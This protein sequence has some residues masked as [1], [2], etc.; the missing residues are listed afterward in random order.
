MTSPLRVGI[1]GSGFGV[2]AHLPALRAHPRFEPV[3]LASPTR[4]I[5]QAKI[6]NIPHAYASALEMIA[7]QNLDAVIIASPPFAHHADTLAALEAGL[8]VL[9]EK[10]MGLSIAECEAMVA[11]EKAA[12]TACGI[13]FEF[14]YVPQRIALRE[15]ITNGH[16]APLRD[17]EITHLLRFL[18]RENHQ[19][20]GWWFQKATGGGIAGAILSHAID[21]AN[22]LVDRAPVHVTGILRTANLHRE[23][24]AG[25]FLSEV[26]DGAF[27]LLD[28]GDGLIARLSVDGCAAVESFT[29]AVHGEDRTA[30]ASGTNT[31]DLRLFSVDEEETNELECAA[32]P[33]ARYASING[34]VPLLVRLYDDW[35]DA[36]DGKGNC[37]PRFTDGLAVQRVLDALGYVRTNAKSAVSSG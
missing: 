3:A 22:F 9:C 11:A 6:H 23:D 8:H 26:D 16:L 25:A 24:T 34:N 31:V 12:G 18:R 5:A 17:I 35:A 27:A 15:L 10:P 37:L 29:I 32:S 13:C 7:A 33:Y 30:V 14:R 4:A 20:R 19:S 36:I 21:A 2:F 1:I 28:Y